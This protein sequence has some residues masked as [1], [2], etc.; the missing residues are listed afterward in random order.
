MKREENSMSNNVNVINKAESDL[1]ITVNN[2]DGSINIIIDKKRK[3]VNLLVLNAGDIFNVDNVEYI[4][5][6]QLPNN[7]TAVIRKELLEDKMEFDSD[8][9]NWRTS[10]IRK[11][12]NGE[13]LDGVKKAFGQDK[14]VE[15]T[16]DLLSMDGLDDYGIS[17]DKVS[18]L[19]IDQYRKY[20]K[21]IGENMDNWWWLITPNSTPSGYSAS[22]VRYVRSDGGVGYGDCDWR[23][24]GVRPFFILQS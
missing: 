9:N 12:L 22:C 16:V 2:V 6:E 20:R 18:L 11:F 14:I 17:T 4:V 8:D 23:C 1:N 21:V 24:R 7:Q 3:D 19:M 15:H 13:Y 5:L 10:S